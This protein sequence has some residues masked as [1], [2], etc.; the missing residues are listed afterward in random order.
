[1]TLSVACWQS[2][3]AS[4]LPVWASV[5]QPYASHRPPPRPRPNPVQVLTRVRQA[6]RPGGAGLL[7]GGGPA[8]RRHSDA[9]GAVPVAVL[10]GPGTHR[11]GHGRERGGRGGRRAR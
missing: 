6:P 2:C 1:M 8:H 11:G 10:P 4:P 3:R 7:G 9:H 5:R